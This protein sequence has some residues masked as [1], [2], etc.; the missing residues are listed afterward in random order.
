MNE[1]TIQ[2]ANYIDK[3]DLNIRVTNCYDSKNVRDVDPVYHKNKH[4]LF[5]W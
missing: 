1:R 4:N 3:A 5:W 2:S